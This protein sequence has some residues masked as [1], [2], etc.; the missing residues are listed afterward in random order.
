MPSTNNIHVI[1]C[2]LANPPAGT[3][4]EP[5]QNFRRS[6]FSSSFRLLTSFQNHSMICS[7]ALSPRYCRESRAWREHNKISAYHLRTCMHYMPLAEHP[8]FWPPVPTYLS[9]SF[10]VIDIN[11]GHSREKKRELIRGKHLQTSLGNNLQTKKAPKKN[12]LC[13]CV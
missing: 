3:L 9:I 4:G 1:T 7:E 6:A 2:R 12:S 8:T 13:T 5:V 11:F 10:P